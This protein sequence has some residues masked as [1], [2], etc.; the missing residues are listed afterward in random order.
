MQGVSDTL[1]IYF[2]GSVIGPTFKFNFDKLI[3][4]LSEFG[5]AIS[6]EFELINTS[7]IPMQFELLIGDNSETDF[8]VTPQLGCVEA[9]S[10]I[11]LTLTFCPTKIQNYLEYL[12]VNVAS[13]GENL[14][15]IPIET[16]SIVPEVIFV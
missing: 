9:N 6:K 11:D 12:V 7:S 16:A 10:A 8:T 13:V 3:L 2:E 14:L 1:D 5:F 4:P 15:R